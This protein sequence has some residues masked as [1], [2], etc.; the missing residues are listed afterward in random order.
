[1]KDHYTFD[2]TFEERILAGMVQT[3][4]LFQR[5]LRLVR[6][7]YFG[8]IPHRDV[9]REVLDYAAKY[10]ARPVRKAIM[11]Q[12]VL[13]RMKRHRQFDSSKF[14]VY[15]EVIDR[16]YD[17]P[18][19]QAEIRFIAE[20]ITSFAQKHALAQAVGKIIEILESNEDA[21]LPEIRLLVDEALTVGVSVDDLGILV[22]EDPDSVLTAQKASVRKRIS[23]GLSRKIDSGLHGG[24]GAGEVGTI[25]GPTGRGKSTTLVNIGVSAVLAG[26]NVV[27]FT[28]ADLHDYEISERY[29]CRMMGWPLETVLLKYEKVRRRLE[30]TKGRL[31]V[32]ERAPNSYTVEDIRAHLS[33]IES[34]HGLRPQLVIVDYADRVQ[35][36]RHRD[37]VRLGV[38][39]VFVDLRKMAVELDL[40]LWT[41]SQSN[42]ASEERL[43]VRQSDVAESYEKACIS[44]LILALCQT[45]GEYQEGRMRIFVAKNRRDRS[46]LQIPVHINRECC[47]IGENELVR[48]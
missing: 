15:K 17:Q 27:H 36:I 11:Y 3:E 1:M 25:L 46:F 23:T 24:L 33:A 34:K 44:D 48:S 42:K 38:A 29:W 8:Y 37:D 32:V 21:S 31:V 13:R 16:L 30:S 47:F 10:H 43:V 39:G 9:A 41:A 2:Q 22:M 28:L 19:D 6:P 14:V 45:I 5:G 12:L 7:A 4:D 35:P 18:L 26:K 40:S 20:E